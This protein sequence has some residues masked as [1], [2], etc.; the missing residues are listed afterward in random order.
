[1]LED[2]NMKADDSNFLIIDRRGFVKYAAAGKIDHD[3][4]EKIKECL[5]TLSQGE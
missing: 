1:M 4:L 2:Y 3:Q 5:Y